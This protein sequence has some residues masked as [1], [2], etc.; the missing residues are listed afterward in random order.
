MEQGSFHVTIIGAGLGGLCLG[1]ALRRR[2]IAFDIHERD[3]S[4]TARPQGYRIRIDRAGREALAACLPP[5]LAALVHETCAVTG[6]PGRFLDPQLAPV[7]GRS[8]ATWRDAAADRCEEDGDL[9]VHRLTLREILLTGLEDRVRFGQAFAGCEPDPGGGLCV[10]FVDGNSVRTDLLVAA[11][12]VG[13]A[14]RRRTLT[15]PEPVDTGAV[16]LYGRVTADADV[17][18]ALRLLAGPAVIFADGFAAILD[19]MTFRPPPVGAAGIT[20]VGDYLYAAFIGPRGRIGFGEALPSP[21]SARLAEG[22][23][24]LLR[25]WHPDLRSLLGRAEPAS[26][27]VLPIRSAAAIHPGAWP[28]GVTFLGD[29]IHVMSPAGGLG[30]NTALA[31]AAQ[32]AVRLGEAASGEAA[33]SEAIATYADDLHRRATAA[34]QASA[35]AAAALFASTSTP[36]TTV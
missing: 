3:P 30:A 32:L 1:Q 29:A 17:T 21:G 23:H 15:D 2:G 10:R 34:V 16:C 18:R 14:V 22:L 13:S 4:L 7:R 27:A 5:G 11:D 8:V 20:P 12:G 31:D 36:L 26:L 19:P 24:A 35:D 25:A 6:S 33:L 9:S 28:R